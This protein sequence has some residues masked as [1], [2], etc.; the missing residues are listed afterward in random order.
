MLIFFIVFI[1]IVV[2]FLLLFL[3]TRRSHSIL[4][5]LSKEEIRPILKR[6]AGRDLPS[7]AEELRAILY[8]Y[9]VLE[10]L[11]V[12]FQT[13]QEGC[14]YTLD[15]FGG[16]NVKREEFPQVEKNP[17]RWIRA[18]FDQGYHF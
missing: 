12:A 10:N 5:E 6:I 18:G 7:K 2:I 16:Q 3:A 13:N 14:L 4:R 15:E 9:S 8:S 17:F 11:Y 1:P